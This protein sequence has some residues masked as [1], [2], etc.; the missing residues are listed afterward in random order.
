LRVL[1]TTSGD[2]RHDAGISFRIWG[3]PGYHPPEI[4]TVAGIGTASDMYCAGVCH[5]HL[6]G[7]QTDH[8]KIRELFV[9]T[10]DSK[11]VENKGVLLEPYRG[12]T[13]GCSDN[14]WELL[15]TQLSEKAAQRYTA[16]QVAHR[17][18]SS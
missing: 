7:T 15:L 3:T 11:G 1:L 17:L 18:L 4:D 13:P 6:L 8:L 9:E 12:N 5:A 14:E 16:E 10:I 2:D